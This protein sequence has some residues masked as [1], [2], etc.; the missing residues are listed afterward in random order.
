MASKFNFHMGGHSPSL[1]TSNQSTPNGPDDD[2]AFNYPPVGSYASDCDL[3]NFFAAMTMNCEKKPTNGHRSS[4]SY[5]WSSG[6]D[7]ESPT[8]IYGNPPYEPVAQPP[9][10]EAPSYADV[11]DMGGYAPPLP[12]HAPIDVYTTSLVRRPTLSQT[13]SHK[14][15]YNFCVFCKN[16]GEDETF[17]LSHTLKDD[18]GRVRCPV[19]WNYQCPICGA[20]GAVSHTIR[21]CPENKDDKYHEDFAAITVLKSMR[22]SVGKRGPPGVI[23]GPPMNNVPPSKRPG[24][25]VSSGIGRNAAWTGPAN[26]PNLMPM[27]GHLVNGDNR[28]RQKALDELCTYANSML[29]Q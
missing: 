3:S 10:Y 21:Y 12:N 25:G 2:T 11:T 1:T 20:T 29:P 19:L 17:Y 14:V 6:T 8:R 22:S 4:S 13:R 28:R 24:S 5:G 15:K 7:S 26:P 27:Y 18:Y 16:N 9:R 23:G